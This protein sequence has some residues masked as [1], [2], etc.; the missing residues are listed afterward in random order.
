MEQKQKLTERVAFRLSKT[1][2]E[3][4]KAKV[5]ESGLTPSDFFRKAVITNKTQIISKAVSQD[6]KHLLFLVN[7]AS[8]NLNQLAHRANSAH[9]AEFIDPRLY[10]GL[11]V[12][13]S[14]ISHELK[15]ALSHVD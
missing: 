7:K 4:Y 6:K 10:E 12:M 14:N 13:L 1:D 11:L 3:S 5:M 2:Y 8:N 15:E 9:Q